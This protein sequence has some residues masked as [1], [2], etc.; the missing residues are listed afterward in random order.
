MQYGKLFIL[1]RARQIK[2]ISNL[3]HRDRRKFVRKTTRAK[4]MQ[5][6]IDSF[7]NS[8]IAETA[9]FEVNKEKWRHI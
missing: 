4:Q 2:K 6:V 9:I 5:R 3:A 1:I 8:F 7:W